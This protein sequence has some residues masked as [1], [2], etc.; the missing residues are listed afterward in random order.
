MLTH[1]NQKI[2]FHQRFLFFGIEW[3]ERKTFKGIQNNSVKPFLKKKT[4]KNVCATNSLDS[5]SSKS[6][7]VDKPLGLG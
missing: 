7:M 1:K 2:H 6:I 3:L 4:G 5:A